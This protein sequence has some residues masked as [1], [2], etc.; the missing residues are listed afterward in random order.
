MALRVSDLRRSR[1]FYLDQ[2]GFELVADSAPDGFTVRCSDG[3]LLLV[4]SNSAADLSGLLTERHAVYEPGEILIFANADVPGVRQTLERNGV[5]DA[6]HSTTE[7]G[8]EVLRITDPDGFRWKWVSAS[9]LTDQQL[10]QLYA[11]APDRLEAAIAD[12]PESALDDLAEGYTWTIRMLVHHICD[13]D[14][15]WAGALLA[16]LIKPGTSY[17]HDWYTTDLAAA[18]AL[19]YTGR[20]IDTAL[21]LFRL[22]RAHTVELVALPDALDRYVEFRR[23]YEMTGSKMTV[24]SMLLARATHTIEHLNEVQAL[25]RDLLQPVSGS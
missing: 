5:G 23:H 1:E 19:D 9:T 24:R 7:W 10:L 20:P 25:R 22:T 18:E 3:D 17:S 13:G 12:L 8:T 16:A 6:R 15:L 14:Q 4:A 2:L 21:R 11:G